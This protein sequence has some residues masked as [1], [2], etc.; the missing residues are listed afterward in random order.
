MKA[1][2]KEF[3]SP[4]PYCRAFQWGDIRVFVGQEP[5]IGWHLSI[6]NP[7][8]YPSWDEIKAARYDL[9]PDNITVAMFLPPKDE[10]VNV[11]GN[12]FHL[13]QYHDNLLD[14]ERTKSVG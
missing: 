13:H 9:M 5:V 1:N 7:Y 14:S 4:V 12:C 10:Y 11:H 3:P 8:R 2:W 6:S